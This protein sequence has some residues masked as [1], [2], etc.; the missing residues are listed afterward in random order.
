MKKEYSGIKVKILTPI[1]LMI[2]VIIATS[3]FSIVSLNKID[4]RIGVIREQTIR[5]MSDIQDIRYNVLHTAEI[6]T[7]VSATHDDG[8]FE[9]AAEFRENVH[10][11]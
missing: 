8:G 11:L 3:A 7:D 4:K 2:L 9:E 5:E 6:L 10:N 1:V